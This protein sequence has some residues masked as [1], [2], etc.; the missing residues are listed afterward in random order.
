MTAVIVYFAFQIDIE[1]EIKDMLLQDN[2]VVE[3]FDEVSDIYGSI[4]Y[5]AIMLKGE[6]VLDTETLN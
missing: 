4:T 6:D 1:A 3:R 5:S 2:P